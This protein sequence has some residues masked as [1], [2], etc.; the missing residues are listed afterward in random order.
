MAWFAIAAIAILVVGSI[1]NWMG[2]AAQTDEI[3]FRGIYFDTTD[4]AANIAMMR[5][6]EMGDWAYQM[7]FTNE[8]HPP[9]FLRMFHILLGHAGHWLNLDVEV[10]F[11]LARWLL[12]ITALY[13]IYRLCEKIFPEKGHARSAFLL[14]SLGA[15]LG[16][17][18][19]MLGAPLEPISPIDFWLIDA[20][21]YFSLSLFPAFA[22][23]LTLMVAALIL[24]LDYLPSQKWSSIWAVC[25]LAIACQIT[26]PIAFSVID[27]A[28][29]GATIF[30]WLQNHKVVKNHVYALAVIASSQVPLLIYSY[31]VLI[32]DPVWFQYTAQNETLSPPPIFYFWGFAPFWPFAI[33]GMIHAIRN[34]T[35]VSGALLGWTLS[36][37]ALAYLPVAIQRRFLLGITIPLGILAIL[38]IKILIERAA[39]KVPRVQK[40]AGLLLFAYVGM[41]SISSV[42]L[43]LGSSLFLKSLPP[44]NFFSAD[45]K[46]ALTWLDQHTE[47]NE[48]V[49]SSAESGQLIGQY[50]HLKAYIGHEMETVN[51]ISKNAEVTAFFEGNAEPGWLEGTSAQWILFGPLE[52][53]LAGRDDFPYPEMKIAYRS[54]EVTIYQL[55]E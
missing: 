6:G 13:C 1:P 15:G 2:A 36:A 17:L 46:D 37:F 21:V 16:W 18:Q 49:L 10:M 3:I 12:G 47:P 32:N 26:N 39:G 25:A 5:A 43:S 27:L 31:N 48:F 50:T 30:H 7:R 8:P 53:A 51:Y 29:V 4:Y 22:Y 24:Y 11:Q 52:R 55:D 45:L 28:F 34:R 41:A 54:E 9:A 35:P 14:A 44:K 19:L 23:T 33:V 38:G 42:Y 20:Y 40:Y